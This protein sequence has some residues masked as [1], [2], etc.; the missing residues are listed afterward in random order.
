MTIPEQEGRPI[1]EPVIIALFLA[2]LL[3]YDGQELLA[4]LG[5][6]MYL[7]GQVRAVLELGVAAMLVWGLMTSIYRAVLWAPADE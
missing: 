3:A 6:R 2:V 4:L 5:G 7:T 1:R